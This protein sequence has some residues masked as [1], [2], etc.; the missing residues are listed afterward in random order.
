MKNKTNKVFCSK[1]ILHSQV[2]NISI[3]EKG[4]CN[5]CEQ[6]LFDRTID[7]KIKKSL[8]KR[9][10]TL[11]EKVKSENHLY[12]ILVLYSGGKDSTALLNLM[13][14]TY[15][16]KI[17][18]LQVI[19]PLVGE[20][21]KKSAEQG[22]KKIGVDLIQIYQDENIYKK[23]VCMTLLNSNKYNL[24]ESGCEICSFLYRWT[25]FRMAM[26]M[27]IPII[28]DGFDKSQG[29]NIYR[30]QEMLN[31]NA[32][33]GIL[34]YGEMH[35][36]FEDI[37][38]DDERIGMYRYNNEDRAKYP[39]PSFIS[40]FTFMDYD[41]RDNVE[42]FGQLGIETTSVAR[43]NNMCKA[44]H[45]FDLVS[46]KKYDCHSFIRHWAN[47]IRYGYPTLSQLESTGNEL[48]E[49]AGRNELI[50][51]MNE[52]KKVLFYVAKTKKDQS[53]DVI[54]QS[55]I[56]MTPTIKSMI[57]P[58]SYDKLLENILYMRTMIDFF[59]IDIDTIE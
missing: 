58:D 8:K 12:D 56:D 33:N 43:I 11:L 4:L 38:G 44:I 7:D 35:K 28:V 29:T 16:M 42:I 1:C 37:I 13:K 21:A 54:K 51:W 24:G 2:P 6:N 45:F 39:L 59:E 46:F 31:S 22:A 30:H 23:F 27:N 50:D 36:I 49:N 10:E 41:Y 17:L 40:P 19:H 32:K 15:K 25:G 18:A 55:I 14:N 5:E 3:N 9:T 53:D 20:N 34:P 47:G 26:Q 48:L 57:T 52:Y